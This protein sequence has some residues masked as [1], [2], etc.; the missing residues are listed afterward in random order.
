[1]LSNFL[2]A[3]ANNLARNKLYAAIGM[4]GLALGLCAA[5]CA[6]LVL[7]DQLTYDQFFDG[8]DRTYLAISE[9][10][11]QGRAPVY[12]PATH[13]SV[14]ALLK[15]RFPEIQS[16]ARLAD[17]VVTLSRGQ[18]ESKET[19]YWAD[20]SL[21]ATLPLIAYA[22]DLSSAL[23]KPGSLVL[24]RSVARKYFGHDAP[25]GET[26]ELDQQHPLTV[27][28]VIEDL[29]SHGTQLQSGIFA[30]GAS[31]YSRLTQLDSDP[32]NL[33]GDAFFVTVSTFVRLSPGAQP[34]R[35]QQQMPAIMHELWPRRPP[36]LGATMELVCI[37]RVHLFPG[38][39]PDARGRLTGTAVIG[40][41]ILLLACINFVNLSTARSTRRALE[42]GIRKSC[43]ADRA[44]LIAQ[45]LTESILHVALACALAMVMT[46]WCLPYLNTFLD[47]NAAV[48]YWRNPVIMA[49]IVLGALVLAPLAGLY[50]AFVVSAFRP[51][52]VLRGTLTH[53]RGASRVW[54]ALVVLQ[55]AALIGLMIA[56]GV[57]YRQKLFATRNT[58]RVPSDQVLLIQSPCN[59]AFKSEIQRMP[60]VRGVGCSSES[61]LADQSFDN[62]R[63]PDGSALALSLMEIDHGVLELYGLQ[64]LAG[65]FLPDTTQTGSTDSAEA[66]EPLRLVINQTAVRALGFASPAVAIGRSL[67][68]SGRDGEIIGVVA[69]FSLNS[70][71]RK[72]N[73]TIYLSDPK[74]FSLITVSLSGH[75]IP[76]TL[77]AIDRLWEKTGGKGPITRHFLSEHIQALYVAMLRQAELFGL[78]VSIAVVLASLGLFALTAAVTERRTREIG[79]RKA[80]GADTTQIM[81][82]LVWQ[83][84]R[85]VLWANVIAWPVGAYVMS[86]WLQG[87][88]YHTDLS[89]WIF[90]GA[91]LI[92]IVI[93]QLTVATQCLLVARGNPIAALRFE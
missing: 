67:T 82:L 81:R 40:A 47:T 22:G 50:P 85:P 41:L 71:K 70:V 90:V 13:N 86:R 68:L 14:A 7:H 12:T 39:D 55:F 48:D 88:A 76:E 53:S 83:F 54:Q 42:V 19:L 92:A 32:A 72:I 38:L 61:I 89:P 23:N 15:L 1:V 63:L 44:I 29:P 62:V 77:D 17:R 35:I 87:F 2:A 49:W 24:T 37:D 43:G 28:A 75:D 56:A 26:L 6:S 78:F 31:A 74:T 4:V 58:L 3:A 21:F 20:A 51:V 79:I 34:T 91:T 84:T 57:V 18:V 60:G 65:R 33:P 59:S 93:A 10:I 36:G 52:T 64:P 11:P 8:Y 69:D 73:P 9:L 16:V 25:L 80:M 27:T 66:R 5:L 45:F 46:E 30:S